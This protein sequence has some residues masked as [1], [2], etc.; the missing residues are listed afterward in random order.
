MTSESSM[1]LGPG[2]LA[3]W[4]LKKRRRRPLSDSSMPVRCPGR[5]RCPGDQGYG[6]VAFMRRSP[7]RSVRQ[8]DPPTASRQSKSR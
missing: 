7:G 5:V 3:I 1:R 8:A 4:R 6:G 2:T